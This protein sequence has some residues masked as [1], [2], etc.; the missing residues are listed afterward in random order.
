[1]SAVKNTD[2]RSWKWNANSSIINVLKY[3]RVCEKDF[4]QSSHLNLSDICIWL[5]TVTP[6]TVCNTHLTA[7]VWQDY[8]FPSTACYKEGGRP[9]PTGSFLFLCLV[10][11]S[12]SLANAYTFCFP[13]Y[14]C[15]QG[16][17]WLSFCYFYSLALQIESF[18]QPSIVP[19]LLM[20]FVSQYCF[21]LPKEKECDSRKRFYSNLRQ[22]L[23]TAVPVSCLMC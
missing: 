22:I 4:L 11:L 16:C 9:A 18:K 15:T 19:T 13:L 3:N 20:D 17:K 14:F 7:H 8:S 5:R 23:V 1:M 21:K 2:K 12:E 10:P 6:T